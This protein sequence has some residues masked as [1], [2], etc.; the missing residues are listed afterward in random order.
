V[1]KIQL[2]NSSFNRNQIIFQEFD[3]DEQYYS[4]S[5]EKK[6]YFSS[7]LYQNP[8]KLEESVLGKCFYM[9]GIGV[10]RLLQRFK[11]VPK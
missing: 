6:Y 7:L 1:A 8:Q 11:I 4:D 9:L 5:K 2:F 10:D 3:S